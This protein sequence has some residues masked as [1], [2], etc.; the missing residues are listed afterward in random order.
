MTLQNLMKNRHRLYLSCLNSYGDLGPGRPDSSFLWHKTS[1]AICLSSPSSLLHSEK[2][3]L[4]NFLLRNQSY[5]NKLA[6]FMNISTVWNNMCK[7]KIKIGKL[8]LWKSTYSYYGGKERKKKV[9]QQHN[10]KSFLIW[11]S[12]VGILASQAWG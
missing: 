10:S 3:S 5:E 1:N 2:M 7:I 4:G 12:V 8:H 9:S 6:L 11:S